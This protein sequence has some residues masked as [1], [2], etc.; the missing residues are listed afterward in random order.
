MAMTW[1]KNS[2]DIT[3]KALKR[4][5]SL[6]TA[7]MDGKWESSLETMALTGEQREVHGEKQHLKS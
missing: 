3:R 7:K 6:I 2:I 1:Q 5:G 4:I